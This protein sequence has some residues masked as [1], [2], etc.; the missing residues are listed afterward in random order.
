MQHHSGNIQRSKRGNSNPKYIPLKNGLGY[1]KR[2]KERCVLRYYLNYEND[3]DFKRG[4][5]ILFFPFQNEM[6]DIHEKDV[7]HLYE[8]NKE[9]INRKREKFE[10]HKVM[11]EIIESIEK[12]GKE[13]DENELEEDEDS[14]IDEDSTT[15]EEL[16]NFE[17]WAKGQA[18][19]SLMKFISIERLILC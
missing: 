13:M 17:D 2:R 5:L 4:L 12:Q 8:A 11:T 3:E 14:F 18:K 1:I 19:K 9:S 16:E 7:N 10:K 6:K 15:R